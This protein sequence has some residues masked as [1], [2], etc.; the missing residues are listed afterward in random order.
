MTVNSV[1]TFWLFAFG[2]VVYVTALVGAL[3]TGQYD[4]LGLSLY[5]ACGVSMFPLGFYGSSFVFEI[6]CSG[7]VQKRLFGLLG[8][9]RMSLA[10]LSEVRMKPDRTKE[11]T[12]V[13]LKF[14]DGQSVALHSFQPRFNK[15]VSF[16]RKS[17]PEAFAAA[18]MESR[19][20]L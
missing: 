14:S 5:L 12:R 9:R 17:C 1:G 3:V 20:K 18:I 4:R 19:W 10:Q 13:I 7:I 16:L 8:S 15:A 2:F 6:D 11:L